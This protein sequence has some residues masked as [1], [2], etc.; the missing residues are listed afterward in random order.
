[1]PAKPVGAPKNTVGLRPADLAA[2]AL[3]DGLGRRP[4]GHQQRGG[5]HAHREAQR[6]AQAVGEEQLGG[7]EA[8]VVL[9]QLQH[10]L[11]VQLGRPVRVGVRVHGALGAAGGARGIEPERRVVGAGGSAGGRRCGLH[12]G[13]QSKAAKLDLGRPCS[14]ASGR[15]TIT[16]LHFVV[17]RVIAARQRRQQ[18]ARHQ[19]R[20]RARVLQHVG[21]VVGGEQRVHRHRHEAG[22]DRAEKAH[23]PVVAVVHQ[24]QHALLAPQAQRAQAGGQAAHAVV[25][26]AVAQRAEVVDEGGLVVPRGVALRAGAGRS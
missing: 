10:A 9:A 25:E 16:L 11:A 14:G 15:D 13:L 23:R 18:R 24:Q 21:V 12:E 1:M 3:E 2:P 20:L 26:F 4:L 22:V 7:G 8:H 6:I 17:A 19:H 5:A